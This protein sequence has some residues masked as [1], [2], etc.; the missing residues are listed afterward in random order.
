MNDELKPLIKDALNFLFEAAGE[1]IE[2]NNLVA[3]NIV[4]KIAEKAEINM[5][6]I[7]SSSDFVDAF[8]S[9]LKTRPLCPETLEAAAKVAENWNGDTADGDT[10][11]IARAIRER[12]GDGS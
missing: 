2:I 4:Y 1:D 11:N 12:K 3:V 5:D 10:R 7:E 6:T 8:I 9:S